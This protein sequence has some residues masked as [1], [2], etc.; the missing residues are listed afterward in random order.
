MYVCVPHEK[1]TAK[2]KNQ[3]YIK[4]NDAEDEKRG[5]KLK[6]MSFEF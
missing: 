3:M 2:K 5:K 4:E 1:N 6:I